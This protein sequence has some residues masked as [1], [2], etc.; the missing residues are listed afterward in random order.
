MPDADDDLRQDLAEVVLA[1]LRAGRTR[2]SP[3]AVAALRI[4]GGEPRRSPEPLS[5]RPARRGRLALAAG[6]AAAV[7]AGGAVLAATTGDHPAGPTATAL[8]TAAA[9]TG[10]TESATAP[11]GSPGTAP[12]PAVER[13]SADAAP[14]AATTP[15]PP[16]PQPA[17]AAAHPDAPA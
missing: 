3:P 7:L 10:T 14:V 17:A 6:A 8:P 11:T 1:E 15:A 2:L 4:L 9:P 16:R 13:R 5:V 12:A